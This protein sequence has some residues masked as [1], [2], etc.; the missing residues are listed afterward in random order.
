MKTQFD[1]AAQT[2][3]VD[4]TPAGKNYRA[5]LNDKSFAVEILRVEDG[6]LNLLI[7]GQP[8]N[9]TVS[10]DGAK[11]WVTVNGQTWVLTKS[12]GGRKS[13]GHGGHTTGELIAPMPGLV[14]AVQ[15]AEGDSV[16]KGQT[17]VI[18]EA[19]KMEIKITA[20]RDGKVKF[21]KVKTG[22]I[23]EREQTLVEIE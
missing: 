2:Y 22:Q 15:V 21:L 11:R 17:L 8:V 1:Q 13:S 7:D 12:S 5:M 20:P 18:V 16:T 23:V 6:H 4:L 9:A 19:M 14:R 3:S 10:T